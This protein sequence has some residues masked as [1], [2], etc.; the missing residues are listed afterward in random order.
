[1][2]DVSRKSVATA[3]AQPQPNV[4]IKSCDKK[5]LTNILFLIHLAFVAVAPNAPK[6]VQQ[7]QYRSEALDK[8]MK[9][10]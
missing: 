4:Q 7:E 2:K 1:M 5:L 8:G 6:P 10:C 9:K 3:Y